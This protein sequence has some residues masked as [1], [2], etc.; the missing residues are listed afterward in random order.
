MST[1]GIFYM[2]LVVFYIMAST[3]VDITGGD[4]GWTDLP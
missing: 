4:V 1:P 3:L 2:Y